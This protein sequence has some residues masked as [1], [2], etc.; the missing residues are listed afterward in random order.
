M[1]NVAFP[2]DS[3]DE[4]NSH[5]LIVRYARELDELLLAYKELGNS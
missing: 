1:D 5:D 4:M 2:D 3:Y